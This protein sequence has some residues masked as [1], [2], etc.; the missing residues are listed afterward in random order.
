MIISK[1]DWFGEIPSSFLCLWFGEILSLSL[2]L[3]QRLVWW[4]SLSHWLVWWNSLSLS[5]RLVWGNSLSLSSFPINSFCSLTHPKHS[6]LNKMS[7]IMKYSSS[8]QMLFISPEQ[9]DITKVSGQHSQRR[10]RQCW[11]LSVHILFRVHW[12][13]LTKTQRLK[14]HCPWHLHNTK[15]IFLSEYQPY[16]TTGQELKAA[17]LSLIQ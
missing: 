5:H 10:K 15:L 8:P 4:Y 17:S 13:Y 6:N 14:F 11:H 12:N 3:S 16:F 2:S 7:I 9:R 1:V